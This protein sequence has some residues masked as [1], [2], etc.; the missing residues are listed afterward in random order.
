VCISWKDTS[1]SR[2]RDSIQSTTLEMS[3]R[4]ST[5]SKIARGILPYAATIASIS[6]AVTLRVEHA[7][8]ENSTPTND[9]RTPVLYPYPEIIARIDSTHSPAPLKPRRRGFPE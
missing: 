4:E 6:L 3:M 9:S 1:R 7:C 2:D 8:T 5:K